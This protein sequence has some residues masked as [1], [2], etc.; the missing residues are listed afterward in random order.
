M[1]KNQISAV[2]ESNHQKTKHHKISNIIHEKIIQIKPSQITSKAGYCL[3]I[4]GYEQFIFFTPARFN[5][6]QS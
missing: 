5:H 3:L 1:I 2:K 4:K 6:P